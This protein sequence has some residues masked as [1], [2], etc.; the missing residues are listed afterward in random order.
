MNKWYTHVNR[1]DQIR[2]MFVM[3]YVPLHRDVIKYLRDCF[4]Y[5]WVNPYMLLVNKTCFG[6]INYMYRYRDVQAYL[7]RVEKAGYVLDI[8]FG[9][10]IWVFF[11]KCEQFVGIVYTVD[12]DYICG[13]STS[14]PGRFILR[15]G[16]R[17][18]YYSP[19][20][21][22]VEDVLNAVVNKKLKKL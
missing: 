4:F 13:C 1:Q 21:L 9:L 11:S 3:K 14:S 12:R 7:K 8:W 17:I 10:P 16:S 15:D 22:T 2:F 18:G 5:D 19:N 20:D 6:V